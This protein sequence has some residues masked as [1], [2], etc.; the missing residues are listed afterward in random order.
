MARLT[1]IYFVSVIWCSAVDDLA[2]LPMD[3]KI[4]AIKARG[5]L[6]VAMHATDH[7]PFFMTADDGSL[8]GI[9]VDLAK[10]LGR[11]LGVS[12]TFNR[13]QDSFD[14]VVAL[15]SRGECDVAISKLSITLKRAERVLYT[16]PYLLMRRSILL[17][18]RVL[19]TL[20]NRVSIDDLI[21]MKNFSVGVIAESSYVSYAAALVAQEK[22]YPSPDWDQS[23]IPKVMRGELFAAF[24]DELEVRQT[25]NHNAEAPLE[26]LAVNL[27]DFSDP[28]A[29]CV[30]LQDVGFQAYLNLFITHYQDNQKLRDTYQ[31]FMEQMRH[32][33]PDEGSN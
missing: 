2:N 29:M 8:V 16:K 14:K 3:P 6:K 9:D 31:R 20:P 17:S 5:E 28:M 26:M 22:I 25:L 11:R 10:D 27:K 21:A 33:K 7:P 15:V 24:R 32:V 1:F 4:A 18:R 30:R 19:A 12:V 13:S 23:I